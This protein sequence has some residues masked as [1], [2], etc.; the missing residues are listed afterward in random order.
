MKE[1]DKIID[2]IMESGDP[3]PDPYTGDFHSANSKAAF[4]E[5]HELFVSKDKDKKAKA[6]KIRATGKAL[7]LSLLYQDELKKA[8][9]TL[10]M[11]SGVGESPEDAQIN[12]CDPWYASVPTFVSSLDR[13]KNDYL[14]D[15]Y[16]TNSIGRRLYLAD[17]KKPPGKM[18]A[19]YFKGEK[20]K[21][22]INFPIQGL[23]SDQ[24][25]FIMSELV[26]FTDKYK[27]NYT[28]GNLKNEDL[29]HTVVFVKESDGLEEEI[30]K[31]D[32][33]KTLVVLEKEGKFFEWDRKVQVTKEF[34]DR[35]VL[36]IV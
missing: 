1:I 28:S 31:L 2:T 4:P 30:D 6:K 3:V 8:G 21:Q 22:A 23:G 36:E 32:D 5:Y 27:L 33:G 9:F 11:N 13:Y 10:H 34:A 15:L 7:G 14:E 12:F 25:K 20:L 26:S 17:W 35:F 19:Y 18:S 16:V 24:I 29:Y